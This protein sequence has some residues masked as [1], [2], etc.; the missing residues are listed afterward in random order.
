MPTKIAIV[1]KN[2]S[3]APSGVNSP[4]RIAL[5]ALEAVSITFFWNIDGDAV[6]SALK[7]MQ[8]NTK[9]SGNL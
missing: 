9:I 1:G 5:I 6:A 3:S 8:M 7:Q 4:A 2:A